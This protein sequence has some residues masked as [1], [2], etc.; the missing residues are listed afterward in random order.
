VSIRWRERAAADARPPDFLHLDERTE[1]EWRGTLAGPIDPF[2]AWLDGQA[3]EDLSIGRPDLETLFRKF[4]ARS[5][6]R[7]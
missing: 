4:Y 5:E 2:I 3:V 1:L 7:P 6:S